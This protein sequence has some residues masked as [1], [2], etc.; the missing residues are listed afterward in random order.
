MAPRRLRPRGFFILGGRISVT[1]RAIA[2]IDGFN[3]Y[4]SIHND[5][6]FHKYKWLDLNSLV[7]RFLTTKEH[8]KEVCYFTAY[9]DWN[10]ARKS[11]HHTYV[12]AL[13]GSGVKVIF[14]Q[15]IEREK[16]ST[17]RCTNPCSVS[18]TKKMCGKTFTFH[19]EKKTDVNI[20]VSILKA[21]ITGS[22]DSIYLL[23]G[24]NDI[25]PALEA[26]KE[27]FPTIDV[28]VILPIN[29]KAKKMMN[30]CS[31]NGF[32]YFRIKEEHLDKAQ[33]PASVVVNGQTFTRPS[34]WV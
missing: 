4:H 10:P 29:A 26:A 24:D 16:A 31:K 5:L 13:E 19:E 33:F 11:R 3:L 18:T 9:T 7:R 1:K 8:L 32:K 17:V 27:L 28:R 20:A 30:T 25:V 15:F 21:C 12:K 34:T 14:G 23:T 2:F 22:C 6:T